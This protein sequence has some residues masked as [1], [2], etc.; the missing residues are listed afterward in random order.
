MVT[1]MAKA[2]LTLKQTEQQLPQIARSATGSAYKRALRVGGVLVYR[3]GE[4]RRIEAD[5]E[6]SFVRKLEPRVRI[7][8]GSKF[9]I[10]PVD[11]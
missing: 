6:N 11:A 1:E 9:E 3:N 2:K 10:K 8:K 7:L 5:G 4:L